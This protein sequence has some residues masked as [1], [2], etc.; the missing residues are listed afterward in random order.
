MN[1]W[2]LKK[3]QD[4]TPDE[5]KIGTDPKDDL[6]LLLE[7]CKRALKNVDEALIRK[8]FDWCLRAHKNQIRKSGDPYYTHPLAVARIVVK[9]IPLDD[10][11]VASALLHDVVDEGQFSIRDIRSE[12]GN[13]IADIVEGISQIQ[14][15]EGYAV[16]QMEN[17]RKILLSWFKDVRIILIKFAER[18]HNMRTIEY[19]TEERQRRIAKETLDI[20]APFCNRFG[21]GNIK[22]ELEDLAFKV[23]DRKTYNEISHK[24]HLTRRQR[25]E[26]IQN[27]VKPIG[28][29]LDNDQ[30]L[31]KKK[32]KYEISGRAKHIYSIYNKT[33]IR[34]KPMEEL[35]DLFAIRII[36]DTDDNSHCFLVLGLITEMYKSVPDTF[37]DYISNPK[38]NGYQS[39]HIAV[40]GPDNKPVEVQ[41][42]TKSMHEIAEKG[43]AAHFNY[44]RGKLPNQS[45]LDNG[46]IEEWMESVRA[47]FENSNDMSMEDL[48]EDVKFSLFFDDI[49]VFT[50]KNECVSLPKDATPLDFAYFIHSDLGNKCIGAKVNSKIVPLN[51]KLKSGDQVE[52]IT[53]KSQ[54]PEKMWLSYVVSSRAKSAIRKYLRDESKRYFELG[55]SAW[56]NLLKEYSYHLTETQFEDIFKSLK[57]ENSQD[58][59][60]AFGKDLIDFTIINELI[61]HVINTDQNNNNVVQSTNHSEKNFLQ[62]AFK[63]INK[64]F[65]VDLNVPINLAT[66]C[67]PLPVDAIVAEI[68]SGKGLMIHR[69]DC[70]AVKNKNSDSVLNI[71]DVKWEW[72]TK[73]EFT[74]KLIIRGDMKP[75][76]IGQITSLVM[77]YSYVPIKGFNFKTDNNNE[78][79]GF[80]IIALKNI[81]TL[82]EIINN[83]LKIDGIRSVN[84]YMTDDNTQD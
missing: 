21:L 81:D 65:Q 2:P 46:E 16:E 4:K 70:P 50:P 71:V 27:F 39:I 17:Y 51:Y 73:N 69:R 42:R 35:Y 44:K 49:S 74:T 18:L 31:R 29:Q 9:D 56:D 68:V 84:R 24:I 37:K 76:L 57:Y 48:I 78:F 53:S 61:Q 14:Q 30:T 26:Y 79:E 47:I 60:I 80:V 75:D 15:I 33:I 10:I 32:I 52:I 82:N 1:I 36:L 59:Y 77:S 3:K 41:I 83:L 64:D 43:L 63:S 72:L 5:I 58:F 23:L 25:E 22:W 7:E 38:K 8:A 66:C 55:K 28:E 12:F 13:T 19:L 20:Y 11:A 67:Y 54:T 40:L 34:Q 6:E 62:N 45:V